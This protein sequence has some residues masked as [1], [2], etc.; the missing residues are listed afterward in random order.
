MYT[1]KS[2]PR[3]GREPTEKWGKKQVRENKRDA[4][5][6]SNNSSNNSNNNSS[7]SSSSN[8]RMKPDPEIRPITTVD[9][10][11]L[12]F[13]FHFFLFCFGKGAVH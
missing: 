8:C 11:N 7:R 3:L 1:S 12:F 5:C 10:T 9:Y 2:Q 6:G 13:V 4:A